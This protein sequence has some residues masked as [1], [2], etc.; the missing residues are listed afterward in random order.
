MAADQVGNRNGDPKLLF[1]GV[2]QTDGHQRIEAHLV[3][4][5]IRI[6]AFGKTE[7]LLDPMTSLLKTCRRDC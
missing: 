1:D 2:G 5:L 4:P 7:R 6:D 3:E